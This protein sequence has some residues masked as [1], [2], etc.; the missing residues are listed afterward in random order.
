MYFYYI[1]FVIDETKKKWSEL[2]H[3]TPVVSGKAENAAQVLLKNTG[4]VFHKQI[5]KN[6]HLQNRLMSYFIK[7]YL[8]HLKIFLL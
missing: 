1:Y 6:L 5:Y 7:T 8:P 3:I 2:F 4:M